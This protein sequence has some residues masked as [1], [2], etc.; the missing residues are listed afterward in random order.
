MHWQTNSL[1]K[2]SN[3]LH[4]D[5][6]I[7]YYVIIVLALMRNI[8][9]AEIPDD[10]RKRITGG[11]C[12]NYK[13]VMAGLLAATLVSSMADSYSL[14]A[15]V[16]V[17][18]LETDAVLT[19]AETEDSTVQDDAVTEENEMVYGD[20]NG[21]ALVD[22][23]DAVMFLKNLAYGMEYALQY[24]LNSDGILN[25]CDYAVMRNYISGNIQY[26]PGDYTDPEWTANYADQGITFTAENV[27]AEDPEF[28][29]SA[30]FIPAGTDYKLGDVFCF[31][32]ETDEASA[33]KIND[34]FVSGS[35][36]TVETYALSDNQWYV[37]VM[38]LDDYEAWDIEIADIS[39][40]VSST[41]ASGAAVEGDVSIGYAYIGNIYGQTAHVAASTAA[42]SYPAFTVEPDGPVEL[43][44]TD[45]DPDP[46]FADLND[47]GNVAMD[48]MDVLLDYLAY[49][50]TY[51][52]D[53]D[54]NSDKEL[55]AADYALLYQHILGNIYYLPI[56][57]SNENWQLEYGDFDCT[58]NADTCTA[59]SMWG[60]ATNYLYPSAAGQAM[61]D[62]ISFRASIPEGTGLRLEDVYADGENC[63][64]AARQISDSER[65]VII[66]NPNSTNDSVMTLD[67]LNVTVS[68][69]GSPTEAEAGTVSITDAH[70][71][72]LYG[73][74]AAIND[75]S[76]DYI[77]P[78]ASEHDSFF[79]DVNNDSELTDE[80]AESMLG[81]IGLPETL[82][83]T[84]EYDFNT[85]GKINA[86]DYVL[87]VNYINGTIPYLPYNIENKQWASNYENFDGTLTG[88]D[89]T[90]E[91]EATLT[92]LDFV[93][94]GQD[95]LPVYD[96]LTFDVEV[97]EDSD[98][99]I[100]GVI[101]NSNALKVSTVYTSD[102]K[103]RVVACIPEVTYDPN[104]SFAQEYYDMLKSIKVYVSRTK[105][106]YTAAEGDVTITNASII[107]LSGQSVP[108]ADAT[109]HVSFP[110]SDS[111][112]VFGDLDEN[113]N[114]SLND[115]DWLM[116]H[117]ANGEA[118]NEA[119][120]MNADGAVNACDYITVY[121]HFFG[122][123]TSL[124]AAGTDADWETNY[125]DYQCGFNADHCQTHETLQYV[126]TYLFPSTASAMGDVM[127]FNVSV[128]E[129]SNLFLTDVYAEGESCI[130]KKYPISATEM[131]VVVY[132]SDNANTSDLVI[133]RLCVTVERAAEIT[134]EVTG[135]VEITNAYI[136][137]VYGQ[138]AAIDDSFAEITFT[139]AAEDTPVFGDLNGD[140]NIDKN[141]AY[142]LSGYLPSEAD[143]YDFEHD[144]NCDGTVNASDF[145]MLMNYVSGGSVSYLPYPMT[146]RLWFTEFNGS[147][148]A[149][150]AVDTETG[151]AVVTLRP[152]DSEMMLI[153]DVL[154][155]QMELVSESDLGIRD[156]LVS[157]YS[158][159]AEF[160]QI[161]ETQYNVIVYNP[162]V[163]FDP[164]H[165]YADDTYASV[166][167]IQVTVGSN[168]ENADAAGEL[169]ITNVTIGNIFGQTHAVPDVSGNVFFSAEAGVLGDV[170]DDSKVD[171]VDAAS[172]LVAAA[173]VGTGSASGMTAQQEA[174]ADVNASG[175]FDAADAALILQYAA[176][177]GSGYKGTL[178]DYLAQ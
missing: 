16:S 75:S 65:Y 4:G 116:R 46:L 23:T 167:K 97:S 42:V 63:V 5:F 49:T 79:G 174:N 24:D 21:D 44:D 118:Y 61:G 45:G 72:S 145:A 17:Q 161:S 29:A 52:A 156:V 170:N 13:K 178:A 122:D 135:K 53:Y 150:T 109:A 128:P 112:R 89:I 143:E 104:S 47:D 166:E 149:D 173:A 175:S 30:S 57:A 8:Q 9:C 142:M 95:S 117:I 7:G 85:D 10:D 6:Y 48:D 91:A 71:G 60:Y 39:V 15:S 115:A 111:E 78:A 162:E 127:A 50:G 1:Q 67:K 86:A 77:F 33:L 40:S 99:Y 26:I 69:G 28:S 159:N 12:M 27:Q 82:G 172:I 140:G 54:M 163:R 153:G 152:A 131:F 14:P 38:N 168:D 88:T 55:D 121:N 83:Y 114:V 96:A 146:D 110:A 103:L 130:T 138:T 134:A 18:A 64:T 119:Y 87:L 136:G 20:F 124:P 165:L 139:A 151:N 98:L 107:T 106:I 126:T 36:C 62:V 108:L 141:D 123:I 43:P 177:V 19:A 155:F 68:R 31:M 76:A 157:G 51:R 22:D 73:E 105:G 100:D 74:T 81:Q 129:N 113:G 32:A 160:N 101:V 25:A 132:N 37:I 70:I 3:F 102:G 94:A 133:D 93:P 148:A 137:S 158:C 154:S 147:F 2:W 144:M 56:S 169:K 80:D 92:E 125:A 171:A 66:Y 35:S 120:D 41:D 176:A 84:A 11:R 34:V 164:N 90:A 59:Y 58:F